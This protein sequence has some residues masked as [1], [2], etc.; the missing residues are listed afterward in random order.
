MNA[1][2]VSVRVDGNVGL[3]E[4]DGTS[5]VTNELASA[6]I[7][8]CRGFSED[9][10]VLAVVLAGPDGAFGD[11][12]A[13][14]RGAREAAAAISALPVPTIAAVNGPASGGGAE[15]A[16]ACDLRVASEDASFQFPHLAWGVVPGAGGT[17]RLPRV[18]GRARALEL[19]L[20]GEKIT[21]RDAW[22]MGLVTK[23]VPSGAALDEAL[24][25]AARFVEKAPIAVRYLREA[26]LQGMELSLEQGLR[27]EADLYFLL[28][29]TAD[30]LE[31]INAFLEKRR[32]LFRG[33]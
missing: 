18:V 26:V 9:H 19:L 3:L 21:A 11:D 15:L 25:L 22:T 12:T 16:L 7:E 4:F 23:V 14:S 8:A 28:Q 32:P 10:T 1:M 17:Q 13:E 31:G 2:H 33:E 6:L 5:G 20:L 30:R 29:T 27:L 24:E